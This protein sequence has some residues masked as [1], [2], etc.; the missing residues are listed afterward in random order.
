MSL[1]EIL[2]MGRSS[3]VWKG[4]HRTGPSGLRQK[5]QGSPH[6]IKWLRIMR[7]GGTADRGNWEE[8]RTLP[9]EEGQSVRSAEV[10]Q[11]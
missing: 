3:C 4:G 2:W 8:G 6:E 10:E 7:F 9:Y 11:V 1:W 5:R